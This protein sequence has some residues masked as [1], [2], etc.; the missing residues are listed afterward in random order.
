MK[1]Q[2][3]REVGEAEAEWK[4]FAK[5]ISTDKGAAICDR[6]AD[7][8]K[9]PMQELDRLLRRWALD[10]PLNI[11]W[12]ERKKRRRGLLWVVGNAIVIL[13]S[14]AGMVAASVLAIRA[15]GSSV[16]ANAIVGLAAMLSFIL[17]AV[18][19]IFRL[20]AGIADVKAQ[21]GIFWEASAAL[22][23]DLFAFEDAWRSKANADPKLWTR[24]ASF[25]EFRAALRAQTRRA[26]AVIAKEQA[27]FFRTFKSPSELV[28]SAS[29]EVDALDARAR[30][31]LASRPSSTS[32][33][34]QSSDRAETIRA[35]IDVVEARQRVLTGEA[36]VAASETE[37][38]R[39][40]FIRPRTPEIEKR[41]EEK[42]LELAHAR[43]R[44]ETARAAADDL[45]RQR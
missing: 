2:M 35:A 11:A 31:L 7:K 28:D 29:R 15:F 40:A 44:L 41:I 21:Y 8:Q 42:E 34:G 10:C 13:L 16:S 38:G 1:R 4:E 25:V 39:L 5:K 9:D 23:E 37:L 18:L 32:G 33:G 43:E 17:A 12:Y 14:T 30:Q 24:E 6:A 45:E 20:F 27:A 22:K 3:R 26:R 36:D 19:G